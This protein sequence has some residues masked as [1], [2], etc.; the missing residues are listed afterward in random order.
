MKCF[1]IRYFSYT[2]N[3]T[4]KQKKTT[5]ISYNKKHPKSLT[6]PE[7]K[8]IKKINIF[9]CFFLMV[10]ALISIVE[11][12]EMDNNFSGTILFVIFSII[13]LI[14]AIVFSQYV[15]RKITIIS[16]NKD[17][18]NFINGIIFVLFIFGF[19]ALANL[20][21]RKVNIGE[22]KCSNFKVLELGES[23][24]KTHQYFLYVE[25]NNTYERLATNKT[26]WNE[27]KVGKNVEL[28]VAKGGLG[29]EFLKSI[30]F[31]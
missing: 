30:N 16:V 27:L 1:L 3:V 8:K 29:M 9:C 19:P 7:K 22:I 15:N 31:K 13:G 14:I 18:A 11:I 10:V 5:V 17:T 21:N 24:Y 23:T 6:E 12:N 4:S 28:C 20:Y 2:Q 26:I 25:I